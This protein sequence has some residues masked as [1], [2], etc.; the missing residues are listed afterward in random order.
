[1]RFPSAAAPAVVCALAVGVAAGSSS[2]V[3]ATTE[4]GA[5]S[6]IRA[7]AQP[8]PVAAGGY[9]VQI[10]EAGG[11]YAVPAGYATLTSWSHSTGGVSGPLT[12]KVYR[13]TGA[14]HE[15]LTIASD[16][17]TVTANTVATFPVQIPVLP[18]DRIGLSA[19]AIHMAFETFDIADR[20]GFFGADPA[21]G[22]VDATDGEPFPD[23]KL[24]VA[25]TLESPP[26]VEPPPTPPAVTSPLAAVSNLRVAPS[27]FRAAR[28]G[29]S[30][31]VSGGL[32]SGA[33]VRYALNVDAKVR[34]TVRR[35]LPGRRSGSGSSARCVAPSR[36][37]RSA[38]RC[39]RSVALAGGFDRT[40]DAGARSFRF[41]G[42][43]AGRALKPGSYVLVATPTAS[44][45]TGEPVRRS[46]KIKR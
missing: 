24:D 46:F 39:T 45:R 16:T 1:M 14:P 11:S 15:F 30:A 27:A 5:V 20:I 7:G 4:I 9:V 25:A 42:R 36:S 37:N 43:I 26:G 40:S 41:T 35:T 12:F 2:A 44:G 32:G 29:P 3:A 23:F 34:F 17:Q 21:P 8:S 6:E 38:R 18:G 28:S 31:R 10:A 19:E 13:P 33:K 22:T